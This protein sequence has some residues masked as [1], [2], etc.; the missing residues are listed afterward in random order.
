MLE[1][2]YERTL[3]TPKPTLSDR[4]W[5]PRIKPK[6]TWGDETEI[7]PPVTRCSY[8]ESVLR[9]EVAEAKSGSR[10][11]TTFGT[12]AYL[13]LLALNPQP[14]DTELRKRLLPSDSSGYDFHRAMRRIATEF[15]S[16]VADWPATKARVKAIKNPA[17]R[18]SAAS[19]AF[20]LRRWV[21]GRAIRLGGDWEQKAR[22]P[23]DVFGMRFSPDFEIEIT[24]V[25]TRVH[26]WKTKKP[27]IT[28]REAIGALGHFVS[29]S[30]PRSVAILSLDKSELF[31]PADVEKSEQLARILA[32][33]IE[34][35][36]NRI[37]TA[38]KQRRESSS[39]DTTVRRP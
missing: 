8:R 23:N 32:L 29:G 37:S 24:G 18:T 31:T 3:E 36:I 39:I 9:V 13:K 17:E 16:G 4:L 33:D 14:R 30:E 10:L 25:W 15:A 35:R 26:I 22:S 20:A 21:D 34:R 1:L 6:L 12:S 28:V 11:M 5:I 19:A 7:P 2:L 38:E 27:P